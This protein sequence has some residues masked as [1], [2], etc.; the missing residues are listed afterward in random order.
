MSTRPLHSVGKGEGRYSDDA[1]GAFEQHF[2]IYLYITLFPLPA[3]HGQSG[4]LTASLFVLRNR[5]RR[6]LLRN[7]INLKCTFCDKKP[8]YTT[9]SRNKICFISFFPRRRNVTLFQGC[10]IGSNNTIFY[11]SIIV[12]IFFKICPIFT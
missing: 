12:K 6:H 4:I 11:N 5:N 10:K 3:P 8:P 1:T 9:D 2:L 7:A